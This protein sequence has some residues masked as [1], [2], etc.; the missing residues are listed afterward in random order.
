MLENHVEHVVHVECFALVGRAR[1]RPLFGYS[2]LHGGQEKQEISFP[3]N[4]FMKTKV[5]KISSRH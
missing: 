3:Y 1:L 4:T 5:A 2:F